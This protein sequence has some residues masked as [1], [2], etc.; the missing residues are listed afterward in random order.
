MYVIF[1]ADD[2]RS[3]EWTFLIAYMSSGVNLS[4][5]I[6]FAEAIDNARC[7]NNIKII[8]IAFFMRFPFKCFLKKYKRA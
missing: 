2:E 8:F 1:F 6:F 4:L 7:K 3:T 5:S